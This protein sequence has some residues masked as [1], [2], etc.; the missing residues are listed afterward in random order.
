MI[1]DHFRPFTLQAA[2]HP[3]RHCHLSYRAFA[4]QASDVAAHRDVAAFEV[5]WRFTVKQRRRMVNQTSTMGPDHR[6]AYE[7]RWEKI[8]Y[9]L[10]CG[11]H[12]TNQPNLKWCWPDCLGHPQNGSSS[13]GG[14]L[15]WIFL[16]ELMSSP[17]PLGDGFEE[18]NHPILS[19]LIGHTILEVASGRY[20]NE[21]GQGATFHLFCR[22]ISFAQVV[23]SSVLISTNCIQLFS[24]LTEKDV[25]KEK[26][27]KTSGRCFP[28][29]ETTLRLWPMA[30]MSLGGQKGWRLESCKKENFP[31][32]GH[33]C[34]QKLLEPPNHD[35]KS[36][37]IGDYYPV[38]TSIR[39]S[40]SIIYPIFGLLY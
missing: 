14:C 6:I 32:R 20:S 40:L 2:R 39:N 11:N 31:T 19:I 7:T 37:N 27:A 29:H 17:E 15:W 21:T 35:S 34:W 5:A 10:T 38:V 30:S 22:Q 36:P 8:M 13:F 33:I 25:H 12:G 28:G 9:Q 18:S 1:S 16:S 23:R 4:H 26:P 24:S 3:P